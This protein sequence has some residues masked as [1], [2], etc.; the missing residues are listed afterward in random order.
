MV[1]TSLA[2]TTSTRRSCRWICSH[3]GADFGFVADEKQ[4]GDGAVCVECLFDAFDDD[5]A[6]VVAT[7]DIHCDSHKRRERE[8]KNRARG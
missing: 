3:G 6:T 7:H 1:R 8:D 5:P 4:G 2:W